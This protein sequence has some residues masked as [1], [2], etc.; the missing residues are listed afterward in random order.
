[1]NSEIFKVENLSSL[2]NNKWKLNEFDER[3]ALSLSQK[4]Q[5][6]LIIGK[7]LSIRNINEENLD[8]FL[9]PN[10]NHHIPDPSKIKDIGIAIKRVIEAIKK[11][12]KIGIIADYDV[13]GS[14]SAAILYKFLKYY[15]CS[16]T[17]KIPNR[18]VDGYGPNLKIMREMQSENI[19]LLFTLDCG[20]TSNNIIDH[21]EF[22]KIDVVVIDHHL[23]HCALPKVHSIINPNR[24]DDESEFKQ[25]AAVGVTFLF[26]MSLRKELRNHKNIIQKNE[27]NLLSYLDLVALGTVCDV[28]DLKKYNR[29]FVSKGLDLIHKRYHKGISKLIDNSKL[30]S[31]PSSQDLG[32]IVG[33]QVNAASRIDDSSLASKLLITNDDEQIE[34]ISRKLFLLNEKRK[35]IESQILEE[36][37]KQAEKQNHSKYI[38]VYGKNWHQGVLGI[39]ASKLLD[40]YNRPIIVLSFINSLGVGS[41][42][43]I[44]GVDLGNIILNAKTKGILLEGGGHSMAAGLKLNY[45]NL[46]GLKKFLDK[47]FQKYENHIFEKIINFDLIISVNDI[48]KNLLDS[49]EKLQPFGKGNPEPYFIISDI[50]IESIKILKNKHILI[51]FENDLGEKIKGICF[52]SKST[53]IGDYLEKYNKYNFYFGCIVTPDKFSRDIKPQLI[54]KDVMKID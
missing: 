12:Q 2:L 33:P 18:L 43:S 30:N 49:L 32:Y 50:K 27:P 1:M 16:I 9:N 35:L 51:F 40:Q 38:L 8:F 47:S 14:T 17:L 15:N 29:L 54:V 22:K 11:N 25:M 36:A 3:T 42:R 41:A 53:I 7:L 10:I 6:P 31:S 39:V 52:N 5:L 34:T 24:L 20:T 21:K 19:D 48:N 44:S 46:D 13:D 23:S 28:V 37:S 4:Y 26:L 45:K